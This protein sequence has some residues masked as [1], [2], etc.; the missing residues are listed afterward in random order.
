MLASGGESLAFM[1]EEDPELLGEALPFALKIY[2]ILLEQDPENTE[3]LLTTGQAFI[4]Y[5]YAYVLTPAEM[6]PDESFEEA[7]QMKARA[8]KLFFRSRGYILKALNIRHPGFIETMESENWEDAVSQTGEEDFPYLYWVGTAWLGAF[9]ADSFDMELLVTLP[10]AVAFLDRVY[11]ADP[12]YDNGGLHEIYISYYGALPEEMG[13]GREK[14]R[15][16]FQRAVELS[17]GVKAGPYVALATAAAVP[18][19]DY[20]EFKHLLNKALE[21]DVDV[22]PKFRLQNILSQRKA[23]WLLEHADDFFLILEEE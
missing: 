6:M 17:G 2:E 16:H 12:D 1:G 13:G 11:E 7:L 3:L 4:L 23:S 20:A 18:E 8:K 19:Q 9:S 22:E 21:I 5:A 14:A 10:R 15:F